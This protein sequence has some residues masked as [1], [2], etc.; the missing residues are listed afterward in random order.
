MRLHSTGLLAAIVTTIVS[1]SCSVEPE[2]TVQAYRKCVQAG[3][4][5]KIGAT[6]VNRFCVHKHESLIPAE[7]SGT[8]GYQHETQWDSA[9]STYKTDGPYYFLTQAK[10]K[11]I[12]YIVTSYRITL[13]RVGGKRQSQLCDF[14]WIEPANEHSDGCGIPASELE[15]HPKDAQD[16]SSTDGKWQWSI[17]E[18]KGLRIAL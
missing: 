7:L 18:V 2:G 12:E 15:Y 16:A 6:A 13:L 1:A 17:F 9:T 5:Q 3:Q 14:R 8:A 4:D 11:S 10:N